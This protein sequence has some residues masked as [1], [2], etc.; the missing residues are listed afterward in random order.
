MK[1]NRGIRWALVLAASLATVSLAWAEAPSDESAPMRKGKRMGHGPHQPM[2][3]GMRA[4]MQ[5]HDARLEE[6][7][8]AMNSAEEEKKVDAIA[9]VVNE[10]VAQRRTR[11]EHIEER[12]KKREGKPGEKGAEADAP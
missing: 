4:Q 9:A 1:R 5:A 7:V 3:A 6:L 10:L 8:A 12:W 2:H 11:R